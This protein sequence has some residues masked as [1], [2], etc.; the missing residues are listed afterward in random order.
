MA[1]DTSNNASNSSYQN[2]MAGLPASDCIPWLAVLITECLAIVIFNIITIIVFVK[3]RRLQRRS[4]SLIIHLA[5]VDLFIV[6]AVSG[7][8]IIDWNIRN[9]CDLWN[10]N[11]KTTWSSFLKPLLRN[12]FVSM[13]IFN[14]VFISLERLHAT[15]LPFKHRLLRKWVYRIV[16]FVIWLVTISRESIIVALH[17]K[18]SLENF[19]NSTYL[20]ICL[21]YIFIFIKVRCSPNPQHQGAADRERKLTVTLILVT[22]TSLSGGCYIPFLKV[23]HIWTTRQSQTF[24]CGHTFI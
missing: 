21:S 6:G 24:P 9:N 22:L 16:T 23:C 15:V 14:L 8:V 13:S 5:I 11:F 1:A 20:S 3:R 7:P 18:T 17:E 4:T 10:Y 19:M 12:L 2:I